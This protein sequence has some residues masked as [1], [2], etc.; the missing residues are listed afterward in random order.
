MILDARRSPR[1][2]QPTRIRMPTKS[3]ARTPVPTEHEVREFLERFDVLGDEDAATHAPTYL[4]S[5]SDDRSQYDYVLTW[6][7][8]GTVLGVTSD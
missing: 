4:E 8:C 1:G 7:T 6:G 5:P 2:L 3:P